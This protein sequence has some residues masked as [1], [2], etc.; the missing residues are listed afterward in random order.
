MAWGS[1][2]SPQTQK[3]NEVEKIKK[4]SYKNYRAKFFAGWT[5]VNVAFGSALVYMAR[6]KQYSI[7]FGVA[8]FIMATIFMKI[9]FACLYWLKA[10]NDRRRANNT[11]RTRSSDVFSDINQNAYGGNII[12]LLCL[13]NA[14]ETYGNAI[15]S[16]II[17]RSYFDSEA[18][19]GFKTS[20][21]LISVIKLI[22]RKARTY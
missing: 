20:V 7:M 12:Y 4:I 22:F 17:L 18:N 9:I 14:F 2:P 1:R 11:I 8:A 13:E 3:P 10:K 16:G 15:D 19:G 6:N 5:M 21:V